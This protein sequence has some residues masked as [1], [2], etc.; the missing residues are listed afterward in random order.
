MLYC[1]FNSHKLSI[2]LSLDFQGPDLMYDYVN[3]VEVPDPFYK[4]PDLI[5]CADVAR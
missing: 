2:F 5:L 1:F 3:G 4:G